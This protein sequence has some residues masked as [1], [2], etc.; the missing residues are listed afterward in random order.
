MRVDSLV[1]SDKLQDSLLGLFH[2]I[3][4]LFDDLLRKLHIPKWLDSLVPRK[5]EDLV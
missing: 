1:L 5:S 2:A 4:S 3:V